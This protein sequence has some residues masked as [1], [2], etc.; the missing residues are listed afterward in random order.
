MSLIVT[1]LSATRLPALRTLRPAWV[2]LEH[3]KG[4]AYVR[5]DHNTPWLRVDG[6]G[7]FLGAETVM[8]HLDAVVAAMAVTV[9]VVQLRNRESIDEAVDRA[10]TMPLMASAHELRIDTAATYPAQ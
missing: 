2:E 9:A 7:R 4:F 1:V 6:D 8:D 5:E 10:A 3:R